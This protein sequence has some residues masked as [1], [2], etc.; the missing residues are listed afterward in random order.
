M[1]R[2]CVPVI[3][4]YRVPFDVFYDAPSQAEAL[5]L[6]GRQAE[7]EAGFLDPA[8]DAVDNQIDDNALQPASYELP[9]LDAVTEEPTPEQEGS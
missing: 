3:A 2:Y 9:E 7:R 6:A 5:R 4:V 1:P 8:N